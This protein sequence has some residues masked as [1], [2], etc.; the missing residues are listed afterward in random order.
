MASK[1]PLEMGCKAKDAVTNFEG[2]ITSK[3]TQL[4]GNVMWGLQPPL[5]KAGDSMP[6]SI[7]VDEHLLIRTGDG[8][9]K[10]ILP[11]DAE[12]KVKLGEEVEDTI[13]S[14][15]GTITS[16]VDYSNG[17][18]YFVV[19]PKGF[20]KDGNKLKDEKFQHSRL[21]RTG[22]GVSQTLAAV[23]AF[24]DPATKTK[25]PGGPMIRVQAFR[26]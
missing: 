21:K 19:D 2:I 6:E 14:F 12:V 23:P 22:A 25:P 3:L 15:A 16:R 1:K 17:C 10:L 7:F 4:R 24:T 26:A 9:S 11:T 5:K 20:D 18:V 13:T 8:V